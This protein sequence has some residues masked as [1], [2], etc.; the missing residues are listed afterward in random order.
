MSWVNPLLPN[1]QDYITFVLNQG[2]P[3]ADLPLIQTTITTTAG[4]DIATAASD[5]GLT[6][7]MIVLSQYVPFQTT[8]ISISGTSITLSA[9]A[10]GSGT[11]LNAYISL[12]FQALQ[13]TFDIATNLV[14]GG[15]TIAGILY[16]LAVYNLGMHNLIGIA[17]DIPGQ[18][19]FVQARKD[20]KVLDFVGGIISGSADQSSSASITTSEMLKNVSI[21]DL[22]LFK[23]PWGRSYAGYA[24]KYGPYVVGVS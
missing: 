12:D 6:V 14:I 8:I 15:N 21:S 4:S 2:P 18:T 17:L 5:T 19:F 23:T 20:F 7:G 24:Q 13:W 3:I 22:D 10:T 16:I 11:G 1:L 9:N